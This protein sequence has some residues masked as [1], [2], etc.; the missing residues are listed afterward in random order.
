MHLIFVWSIQRCECYRCFIEFASY[1]YKTTFCVF[2]NMF[3][4]KI[5][6]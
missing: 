5:G 3:Y 2:L 6:I 1:K 4:S